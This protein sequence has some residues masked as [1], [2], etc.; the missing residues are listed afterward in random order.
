M[1][2]QEPV[3]TATNDARIAAV[4]GASFRAVAWIGPVVMI[5]GTAIGSG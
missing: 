5:L 4:P 2:R 1:T 3:N